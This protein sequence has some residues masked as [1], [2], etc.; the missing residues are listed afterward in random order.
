MSEYTELT[1]VEQELQ[2]AKEKLAKYKTIRSAV[3]SLP[4]Q[5]SICDENYKTASTFTSD[6]IISRESIDAG[7][8]QEIDDNHKK[9]QDDFDEMIEQGNQ[10]VAKYEEK[11]AMLE[12]ERSRILAEIEAMEEA[13]R[14]AAENITKPSVNNNTFPQSTK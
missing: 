5:L 6:I 1:I 2:E 4:N 10:L 12:A 13:A 14:R 3:S 7:A 9:I 11:I 8:M